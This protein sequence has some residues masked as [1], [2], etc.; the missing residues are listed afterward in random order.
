MNDRYLFKAKRVDNGKWVQGY[1]YQIWE[2]GYI[3]WGMTNDVPNRTA[4]EA[5]LTILK[6][7]G[8][9]NDLR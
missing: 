8:K 2:N 9:S 6:L 4:S 1:Y 7:V 5:E 3:L